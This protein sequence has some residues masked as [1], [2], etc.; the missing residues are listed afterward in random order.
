MNKKFTDIFEKRCIPDEL[1]PKLCLDFTEDDEDLLSFYK[2]NH[3]L[4]LYGFYYKTPLKTTQKMMINKIN[5]WY[6]GINK[7]EIEDGS[8]LKQTNTISFKTSI[9]KTFYKES[10]YKM[11]LKTPLHFIFV[12][13]ENL[14]MKGMQ[15]IDKTNLKED[16]KG[17]LMDL[18]TAVNFGV[19]F[20]VGNLDIK[21]KN[22]YI[23]FIY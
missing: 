17:I 18:E 23:G 15:L 16:K 8:H 12:T 2:Q 7:L 10:F 22:I 11:L 20:I 19:D 13:N 5:G 14:K 21:A 4:N 1:F 3:L 9:D 6:L